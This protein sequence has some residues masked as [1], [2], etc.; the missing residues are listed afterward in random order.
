MTNLLTPRQKV[1]EFMQLPYHRQWERA[2]KLELLEQGDD[3]L[4][5]TDLLLRWMARARQKGCV[6]ELLV[7][8]SEGR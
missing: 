2:K 4:K 6:E 3:D 7:G 5:G 8:D 1:Y